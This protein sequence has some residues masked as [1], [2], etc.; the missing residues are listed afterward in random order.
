MAALG[1][2]CL[3]PPSRRRTVSGTPRLPRART[4]RKPRVH[5][6]ENSCF[7][8]EECYVYPLLLLSPL[9][10][11]TVGDESL[12]S[13]FLRLSLVVTTEVLVFH[14]SNISACNIP[15]NPHEASRKKLRLSG[16]P[17]NY[18]RPVWAVNTEFRKCTRMVYCQMFATCVVKT[19]K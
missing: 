15:I 12:R 16:F 19:D 10:K 8:D 4:G 5:Q 14:K 18:L 11:T 7:L 2:W 17:A 1:R 6:L 13:N 3:P 9:V